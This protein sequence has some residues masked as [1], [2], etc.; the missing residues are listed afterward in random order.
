MGFDEF[1]ECRW[2]IYFIDNA[3][4][5]ACLVA[6]CVYQVAETAPDFFNALFSFTMIALCLWIYA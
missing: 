1:V 5:E 4:C 6:K 3:W 2:L